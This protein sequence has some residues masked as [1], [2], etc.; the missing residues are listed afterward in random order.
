M[1]YY[2]KREKYKTFYILV[3]LV[4]L[5]ERPHYRTWVGN[6]VIIVLLTLC[7]PGNNIQKPH[8]SNGKGQ[9]WQLSRIREQLHDFI[10]FVLFA[11]TAYLQSL[12]EEEIKVKT[13]IQDPAVMI[14]NTYDIDAF[15][16][17]CS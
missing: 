9:N 13:N 10:V 2:K 3:N 8:A 12:Q 16:K 14:Y 1:E 6:K 17:L 7:F 5:K 4:I 15:V 11:T